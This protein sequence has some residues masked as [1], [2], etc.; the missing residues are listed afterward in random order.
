MPIRFAEH[1]GW[2]VAV[3]AAVIAFAA[4]LALAFAASAFAQQSTQAD[5]DPLKR[6]IEEVEGWASREGL[7]AQTLADLRRRIVGIGD[8]LRGRIAELEPRYTEA[9]A[10]VKQLGAVPAKDAPAE[11]PAVAAEREQMNQAFSELDGSLK[12]ARLLVV[13]TDQLTER[14]NAQRQSL[15][16]R[17]LFQRSPS[18]LDPSLWTEAG[19][20][21]PGELRRR[22][23]LFELWA[24]T[25]QGPTGLL[26]VAGALLTL[27]FIV[28]VAVAITRWWLPRFDIR[29]HAE[30]RF[31][32][33][34]TGFLVAL[35]LAI[36][37]PL[38]VVAGLIAL[39]VFGLWPRR[40]EEL[41]AGIVA[42]TAAAAFGRGVARGLLAPDSPVRRLVAIDDM[43]AVC[44]HDHL[45]W[46]TRALGILMALQVLHK[47]LYAPLALTIATNA[48]FGIAIVALLVHLVFC[49]RRVQQAAPDAPVA[50]PWVKPLAWFFAA[51]IV[52]ALVIGYAGFAA[53]IAFRVVVAAAVLCALYLLL[54]IA[55]ALFTDALDENTARGR[56]LASNLGIAHRN[57]AIAGTLLSA[58]IRVVL[59]LLAIVVVIGPWEVS[60]ADLLSTV[61]STSLSFRI[62]EV[63][64]SF[65]AIVSAAAALLI[66]LFVTRLGQ[67]WLQTQLLPRTALEP[68]LQLSI[69]TIFGYIGVIIAVMMAMG[70]LGIDLQKI[71]FVAGALSVGIGFGLQAIVSNFVSGLILLAERPIR[72]GDSIVVKG[73]E[74]WVRRIRVRATEIE[75]FD[76][77]AVIVPNSELITGV[78]KNWTH[79]NTMGRIVVKIGVGYD[80]D[81][82]RVRE[83]L[84]AIATEHPQVLKT[85]PPRA[86]LVAFGDSALSFEL[87]CVV[88]DVE[89]GMSVKSDLHFALLARFRAAGIEIPYP[90]QEVRLKGDA[91]K[92]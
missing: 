43:T 67:R 38:A 75:T 36:R 37:T 34:R 58:G 7:S 12:Q 31:A 15:Y 45:V 87:R 85:P 90:Q 35:W 80:S 22:V 25:A 63:S 73:E 26:R 1:L 56:A 24:D 55:D 40:F 81:P 66:V 57:I 39:E 2:R 84:T 32:K 74:G 89:N 16:A 64:I 18:A 79:A 5:L 76:R 86:F 82:E 44:L 46:T 50:A 92:A 23:A 68:S 19:S 33:A 51:A 49:L 27:A 3:R 88:S 91:A 6:S 28:F 9:E 77:A 14:L 83:I 52:T 53:F 62:G 10:R 17:E 20:A 69:A 59:I 41:G 65:R 21:I 54:V 60:T 78:V 30:T 71:A 4:L 11:S 48:V 70:S 61:Q 29:G 72:V 47:T 13:R 42:G 8:E